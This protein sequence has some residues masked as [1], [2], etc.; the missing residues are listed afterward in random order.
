MD[1]HKGKAIYDRI[2]A[3]TQIGPRRKAI[4]EMRKNSEADY[5]N[6][7]KYQTNLR[8]QKYMKDPD[9]RKTVYENNKQW[10]KD[11]GYYKSKKQP[12][13][14]VQGYVQR[15]RDRLKVKKLAKTLQSLDIYDLAARAKNK[16]G[17]NKIV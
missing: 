13:P 3:I 7:I 1:T 6:Y 2:Q 9:N 14:I 8:K 15:V 12:N 5:N 10:K 4:A 17:K 11:N 16:R